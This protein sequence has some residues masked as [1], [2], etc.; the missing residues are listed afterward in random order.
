MTRSRRSKTALGQLEARLSE[1]NVEREKVIRN[2]KAV[3][4][5]LTVGTSTL[6]AAERKELRPAV[7]A[8]RKFSRAA[9]AKL[10]ASATRRWAAAK[11]AG[12][13]RLG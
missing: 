5:G 1:L 11:K 8:V 7:R 3:V 9:R 10:A 6:I 4:A 2:L 12:K 13:S